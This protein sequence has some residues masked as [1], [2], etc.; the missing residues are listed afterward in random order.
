MIAINKVKPA[1]YNPRKIS[2][3]QFE[4]LKQSITEHGFVMPILV[5][6]KNHTIIAGHQRTKAA[7]AIGIT[8]VPVFYIDDINLADEIRFNQIHNGTDNEYNGMVY[9]KNERETGFYTLPVSE[10]HIKDKNATVVKEICKL[11]LKYGNVLCCVIDGKG[12]LVGSNY[13]HACKL[14]GLDVNTSVIRTSEKRNLLQEE[15]GVFTYE[16]LE[17]N[18]WVKGLAQ[19]FRD[20][21][22]KDTGKKKNKSSLYTNLVI[23]WLAGKKLSILDFGCGKG[24]YI[25]SFNSKNAIGVEF[26]NNNSKSI[27]VAKG[28]RQID[29]MIKHIEINGPF[30]V[31]VCDSVMNS[32]DSLEAEEAVVGSLNSL[33]SL[34]GHMFISGRT[35]EAVSSNI[36][37]KK[38]RNV[39]KRLIEFL[40]A[41]KFTAN[42]RKGKW[43]YQHFHDKKDITSL[44]ER[45]GFEIEELIYNKF[46]HT[47]QVRARKVAEIPDE[48][49]KK[50]IDFEFN[51]PLPEGNTYKRHTDVKK[52]LDLH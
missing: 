27:D 18:T 30:D 39:G 52:V 41:D 29:A 5:N 24:A 48:A 15:Y 43:Y 20:T 4:K 33:C 38:D 2:E 40:D 26:Y 42:F 22:E 21:T 12:S 9:L 35:V 50:A 32:V 13:V 16:E 3:K 17:K 44:I 49:K 23:P 28:N 51:L 10:F 6:R 8:E 11:I 46:S 37:L 36:N 14:L 31:V 19:M 45:F 25:K 7:T 34:N 1:N 47:W